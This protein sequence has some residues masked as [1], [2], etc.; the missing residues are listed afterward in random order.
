MKLF[1]RLKFLGDILN[2]I[3]GWIQQLW[4]LTSVSDVAKWK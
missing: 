3:I 2:Y 4:V 1:D